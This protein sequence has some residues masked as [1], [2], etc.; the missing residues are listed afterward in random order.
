MTL[1][2]LLRAM[3]VAVLVTLPLSST[4][5]QPVEP[6]R[7][8]LEVNGDDPAR[9]A[10][11]YRN[12]QN[13]FVL[14]KKEQL[15]RVSIFDTAGQ[16]ILRPA[17]ASFSVPVSAAPFVVRVGEA[18]AVVALPP[19]L[20]KSP[21]QP[22]APRL[23]APAATQSSQ[24]ESP[25]T[26]REAQVPPVP[27]LQVEAAPVAPRDTTAP[28]DRQSNA[29]LTDTNT[30]QSA[31]DP[32]VP[33]TAS[34]VSAEMPHVAPTL[35]SRE[36]HNQRQANEVDPSPIAALRLSTTLSLSDSRL[37]GSISL[38]TISRPTTF[39]ATAGTRLSVALR[40]FATEHD[41]ED[42]VWRAPSDY[43]LE[44]DVVFQGPSFAQTLQKVLEPFALSAELYRGNRAIL[45]L[46]GPSTK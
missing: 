11:V 33:A 4:A 32:A 41:W 16:L 27:A 1:Y 5:T 10:Q 29:D 37:A 46:E 3:V 12:E 45:I 8:D 44:N 30:K 21:G 22:V 19:N 42:L 23:P 17:T 2:N 34:A 43:Q 20:P 36:E 13:I 9:P 31:S 35:P 14:L 28:I 40:K 18:N 25:V 15:G 26:Q 7:S 6:M 38:S 39:R 24:P